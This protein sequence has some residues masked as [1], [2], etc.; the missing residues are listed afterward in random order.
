MIVSWTTAKGKMAK[1]VFLRNTM[2]CRKAGDGCKATEKITYQV[3][4]RL[5]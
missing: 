1:K 2:P 4:G 3:Y 5:W